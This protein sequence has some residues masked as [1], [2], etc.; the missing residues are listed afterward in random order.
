MVRFA[1]ESEVF[2]HIGLEWSVDNPVHSVTDV[3]HEK[4]DTGSNDTTWQE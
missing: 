2:I 1:L 3:V 4:T